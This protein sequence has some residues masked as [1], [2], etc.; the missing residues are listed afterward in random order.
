MK[1]L[2]LFI[3]LS[4]FVFMGIEFIKEINTGRQNLY[5]EYK[6]NKQNGKKTLIRGI[7]G[8]SIEIIIILYFL[9]LLLYYSLH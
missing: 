7:I 3:I 5:S 1:Y 4:F 8:L 6:E 9:V 2:G